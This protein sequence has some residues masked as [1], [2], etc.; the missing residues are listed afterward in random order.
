MAVMTGNL[1]DAGQVPMAGLRAR[2]WWVLNRTTL[3]QG[4]VV[5]ARP[6]EASITGDR[7]SVNVEPTGAGEFYTIRVEWLDPEGRPWGW[8]EL[9]RRIEVPEEGG[10]LSGSTAVVITPDR[11]AVSLE[12]P[13]QD[14]PFWLQA[15]I[16][17]PD[18]GTSTGSGDLYRLVN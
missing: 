17:D 14:F 18:P 4:G 10:D 3:H 13:E 16:G 9:D 8:T 1:L 11:V 6:I 2:M 7:F 5:V 12:Q 15:A